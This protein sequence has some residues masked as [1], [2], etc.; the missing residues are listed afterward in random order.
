MH[1]ILSEYTYRYRIYPNKKQE[2]TIHKIFGCCRFVYNHYLAMRI[3]SYKERGETLNY[4][5]CSNDLTSLKGELLWLREADATALQSSLRD[6][7][8]AFQNFFRG[9]KNGQRIGFPKFKSKRNERRSYKSKCVGT[10]IRVIDD[11]HIQLPKLGTVRCT[12]SKHVQGRILSATVSQVPSGKYFVSLCCTDVN[13]D[14]LPKT[15]AVVGVDL[16]IKSL[17][18]TSDG[19]VYPNNKYL[20]KSDKKLRRLSRNLSRKKKGSNNYEKARIRKAVLEEHIANQR[21]DAVQKTTTDLIR[22]FDVICIENL[23]TKGMM[24]NHHLA[25]SVADASFYEFRR[26]LEYKAKWYGKMVSVIDT[27]YPSSQL[28]SDCGYKN[29]ETKNLKVREWTC[30]VCGKHHDRDINAAINILNE[31]MRLLA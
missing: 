6:L 5:A 16:G 14:P 20:Y 12:I 25:R 15:G 4:V 9:V 18:K 2:E 11:N 21:R 28:C 23:K 13:I 17:A 7:D 31:G 29:T 22:N 8:D 10:T 26:E 1:V 24:Q 30:P 3:E 27:F 19:V